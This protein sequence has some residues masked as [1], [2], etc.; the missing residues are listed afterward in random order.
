MKKIIQYV[1]SNPLMGKLL[2][3]V[4]LCST[5]VASTAVILQLYRNYGEDID[6]IYSRLEQVK[7]SNVE[8][9]SRDLLNN[10]VAQLQTQIDGLLKVD[11]IVG[12]VVEWQ[13][14]K[15]RWQ[16]RSVY[17]DIFSEKDLT[18]RPSQFIVKHF[19]L[20]LDNENEGSDYLGELTVIAS[21]DNVYQK[22]WS[23]SLFSVVVQGAATLLISIL[24]SV[25]VY[26]LFARHIKTIASYTREVS[27]ENLHMPLQLNR[28][29]YDS[30]PDEL[31]DVVSAINH[32]RET[33]LDD[34]EKRQNIEKALQR[35]KE[36]RLESQRQKEFAEQSS[37]AKSQFLAVMSHEIRTP[38]NGV[39]GMLEMLR[40]TSLDVDQRHYV[41]V[42]Y[43]SGENLL[44]ILNDIL[45]YSKIEAQKMELEETQFNLDEVIESSLGLFTA[46]AEK[47]KIELFGVIA[48]NVPRF[49]Y[50]D[51]LRLRQII[52]NLLSN[53]FKFTEQGHIYIT[54]SSDY[55]SPQD[56]AHITIRVYD[57]GIG[58]DEEYI[59]ELFGFFNQADV[60]ITRRYGG[61]GL[62]LAICKNLVEL[63]GGEI[64]VESPDATGS[65][66]WFSVNLKVLPFEVALLPNNLLK[67]KSAVMLGASPLLRR[68]M[69]R[70]NSH[71]QLDLHYAHTYEDLVIIQHALV[72]KLDGLIG[73]VAYSEQLD[74]PALETIVKFAAACPNALNLF[75][76]GHMDTA[77]KYFSHHPNI[78]LIWVRIP[79]MLNRLFYEIYRADN[80]SSLLLEHVDPV[81]EIR[82]KLKHGR[83]LVAEDNEVNQ[84]V[85]RGLLDK[86]S[87][88]SRFVGNGAD[89][90]AWVKAGALADID[91]ILMDCEMPIMDG[92]EAARKIRAFEK[93]HHLSAKPIIALTAHALPEHRAAAIEAGMNAHL[94]KPV[95]LDRLKDALY[96]VL[97]DIH[98]Q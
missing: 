3:L 96:E 79:L 16:K 88:E 67:N 43:K 68:E 97:K 13:D 4:V 30:V 73:I 28:R 6:T 81:A 31:D 25:F 14:H 92:F 58:L 87:I 1:R 70:K 86:L 80:A 54:V 62:G 38:L 75:V 29:K 32:M 44:N 50:G 33:L 91:A 17:S 27:L 49:L 74:L 51:P 85:I 76:I 24:F 5:T 8:T 98:E 77:K 56:H 66:F 52:V 78:R 90:V 55:V 45:D 64:G 69:V 35:E 57:S 72:D 26:A 2:V 39:I 21:L 42:I 94:A 34:I 12:I 93:T 63:M 11:G 46:V 53:A 22:L 48:P 20:H 15:A 61:T 59:D 47:N 19:P 83:L 84:M 82:L 18:L 7:L 89:V 41:D 37:R 60:S 23:R 10:D 65:Q 40:D 71:W 95:T 36:D 9:L